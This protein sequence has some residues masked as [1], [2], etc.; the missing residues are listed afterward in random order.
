VILRDLPSGVGFALI[1][2]AVAATP[3]SRILGGR[4]LASL[5]AISYGFYLWHV[6]ILLFMRGHGLLPLDPVL[7]TFAA[8]GPVL[9][10]STLSWVALERPIIGWARERDARA[11]DERRERERRR[12]VPASASGSGGVDRRAGGREVS[13][14][15]S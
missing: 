9:A 3:S 6:P 14:V 5:G 1:V 2:G 4:V 12:P 7:G 15:R 8:I 11:R 13:T 10:V